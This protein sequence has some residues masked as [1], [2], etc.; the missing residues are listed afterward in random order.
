MTDDTLFDAM[1]L[2]VPESLRASE[3]VWLRPENLSA[4]ERVDRLAAD[5][6]LITEMRSLGFRGP[7]WDEVANELARYGCAVIG[8]WIHRDQ[9]QR[10]CAKKSIPAPPISGALREDA[11]A[12]SSVV[13]E[14]VAR[15][16]VAF[17]D[18]VLLPGIWDPQRGA[19]LKT[20]FVGQ[21]LKH[22][23]NAVRYWER[24][25]A[26]TRRLANAELELSLLES[27]WSGSVEHDVLVSVAAA[28]VL[29][30]ASSPRAAQALRMEAVG[31][32]HVEIADCLSTTV[33]SVKSILKRE[34]ARVKGRE[35]RAG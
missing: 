26:P 10:E 8:A 18:D 7:D 35:G 17:R 12:I 15:A 29:R 19:S 4:E 11:Q 3:A 5:A 25:E 6:A 24:H 13:D 9:I 1:G 14:I 23:A 16:S 21:C 2:P 20:F 28:D 33:N 30:G 32:S 27:A 31:Y 22:Y 34:R